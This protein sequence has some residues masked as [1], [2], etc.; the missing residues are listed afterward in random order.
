MYVRESCFEVVCAKF[1]KI[2]NIYSSVLI[3]P[4]DYKLPNYVRLLFDPEK[5]KEAEDTVKNIL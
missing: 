2:K 1:N 5:A 3:A 4:F